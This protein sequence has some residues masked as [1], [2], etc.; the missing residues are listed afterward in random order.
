MANPQKKT[1]AEK[2]DAKLEERVD[3]TQIFQGLSSMRQER[4]STQILASLST[5]MFS[6]FSS[7]ANS[8]ALQI[9]VN[10]YKLAKVYLVNMTLY[11]LI[12]GMVDG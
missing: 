4:A 3:K 10:C 6:K 1:Q 8:R 7:T 2:L 11:H 5:I 12:I 9:G